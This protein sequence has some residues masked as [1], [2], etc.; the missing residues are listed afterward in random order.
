MDNKYTTFRIKRTSLERLRCLA[1]IGFRSPPE[2]LDA[3]IEAFEKLN[4]QSV[5][6]L[7]RPPGA[8]VVPVVTITKATG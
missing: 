8:N 6:M 3:M 1:H 7:P 4:I 5:T 2:Q